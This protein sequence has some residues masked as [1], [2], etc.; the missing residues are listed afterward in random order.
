[1]GVFGFA[2]ED[3]FDLLIQQA[4]ARNGFDWL[5]LKAL[6]AK[7]SSFDPKAFRL[8]PGLQDAS[9]GLTQTLF[10]TAKGEG[11]PGQLDGLFDPATS[12]TYGASYFAKQYRRYFDNYADAYA[13]YNAGSA[14][15]DAEGFYTNSKGDRQVDVNVRKFMEYYTGYRQAAGLPPPS[16]Q[17]GE[18]QQETS[19]GSYTVEP[20][21]IVDQVSQAVQGA[22]DT[23][24]GFF[25]GGS[26]ATDQGADQAGQPGVTWGLWAGV[27]ALLAV[28]ALVE[29]AE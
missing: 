9:R 20:P 11:Y 3:E 16:G 23:V 14:Y 8:E 17:T 24:Q 7:E 6:V 29:A 10:T 2:R 18:A 4:A 19:A 5:A 12:I 26:P 27:A 15:Q 13:A 22:W 28:W 25:G 21:G 1:M